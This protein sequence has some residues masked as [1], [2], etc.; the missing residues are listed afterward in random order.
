[1]APL[2]L[3]GQDAWGLGKSGEPGER[4]ARQSPAVLGVKPAFEDADA[5]SFLAFLPAQLKAESSPTLDI[6]FHRQIKW[7]RWK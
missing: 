7:P 6:N 4:L 2:F 5:G 3:Q 1:M